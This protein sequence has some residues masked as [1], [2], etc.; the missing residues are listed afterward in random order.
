MDIYLTTKTWEDYYEANKN[1]L[2]T[3]DQQQQYDALQEV[4]VYT[5]RQQLSSPFVGVDWS[6]G[7]ASRWGWRIH[8]ISGELKQHLGLDIAMPGGTPINAC[9]AGTI[10]TGSDA[11]GWGNYIKV[12][13]ADGSYTLYGHMSGFAVANG[14]TVN[15]G[16]VIGY[17]GTT[18][19]STGNHLHLEYHDKDNR[20]LNPLIFTECEKT[21]P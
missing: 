12:V 5:F 16:D 2:L 19:A 11:S 13:A 18:G 1:T 21:T 15:P 7:V 17:V 4:G 14:Q 8:P 6:V 10:V 9:N 20:N 3:P